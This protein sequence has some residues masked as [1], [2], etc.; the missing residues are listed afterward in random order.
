ML[1]SNDKFEKLK[2]IPK[3]KTEEINAML[4][5]IADERFG[6][7]PFHSSEGKD[8]FV[9]DTLKSIEDGTLHQQVLIDMY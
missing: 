3:E 2:T 5:E 9:S 4:K 1:K 8:K 7:I 6:K